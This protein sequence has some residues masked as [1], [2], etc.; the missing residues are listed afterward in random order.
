MVAARKVRVF[1]TKTLE[2]ER[3]LNSDLDSLIKDFRL[4]KEGA[5]IPYFGK[6]VPY[7]RPAPYAEKAGLMHIHILDKLKVVKMRSGNTS[8]SVLIYTEGS[9]NQNTY[10]II[11]YVPDGAH[12]RARGKEY[13]SWLIDTAESFRMKI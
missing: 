7:R 6:E 12:A 1:V 4:Y 13:M 3:K 5:R 8:D 11:D 9:M 2:G 10:Y